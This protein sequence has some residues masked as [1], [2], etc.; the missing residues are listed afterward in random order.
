LQGL[1]PFP[2]KRREILIFFFLPWKLQGLS[3]AY[4]PA[5]DQIIQYERKARGPAPAPARFRPTEFRRGPPPAPGRKKPPPSPRRAGAHENT[6]SLARQIYQLGFDEFAKKEAEHSGKTVVACRNSRRGGGGGV[7][8][9]PR[10]LIQQL[11]ST[12]HGQASTSFFRPSSRCRKNAEYHQHHLAQPKSLRRPRESRAARPRAGIDRA[13]RGWRSRSS[14]GPFPRLKGPMNE[15]TILRQPNSFYYSQPCLR[16]NTRQET[17][18][19]PW[20]RPAKPRHPTPPASPGQQGPPG[21]ALGLSSG[22]E[23]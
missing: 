15:L 2:K 12:P 7:Q 11:C 22:N 10:C 18:P 6:G 8:K 14:R 23:A 9:N 20:K 4:T 19:A 16:A 17:R 3:R 21:A 5:L 13:Q 1:N